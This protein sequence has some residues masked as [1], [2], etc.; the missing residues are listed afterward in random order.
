MLQLALFT[1]TTIGQIV[2]GP[3]SYNGH[4]VEVTGTVEHLVAKI[5]PRGNAYVTFLLCNGQC[6]NVYAS[7]TPNISEGDTITIQGVFEHTIHDGGTTIDNTIHADEGS[8]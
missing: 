5:A 6:V 7:G 1:L 3:S 8:I 2:A 4:H